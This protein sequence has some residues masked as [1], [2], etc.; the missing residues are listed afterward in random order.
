MTS[1]A[2]KSLHRKTSRHF[3][4]VKSFV[5]FITVKKLTIIIMASSQHLNY[6][7]TRW[8]FLYLLLIYGLLPSAFVTISQWG[9]KRDMWINESY[10]LPTDFVFFLLG[11]I[12]WCQL[13]SR[14]VSQL[15]AANQPKTEGEQGGKKC[16]QNR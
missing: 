2:S 16:R 5:I 8:C 9:R 4:L 12:T 10:R 15:S 13:H 7:K 11:S 14:K 1:R 3:D 6:L